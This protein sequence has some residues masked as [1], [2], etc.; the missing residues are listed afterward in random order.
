MKLS[1]ERNSMQCTFTCHDHILALK[2]QSSLFSNG[3]FSSQGQF[4]VFGTSHI[5]VK[6]QIVKQYCKQSITREAEKAVKPNQIIFLRHSFA[7][8]LCKSFYCQ[9]ITAIL[10]RT[11]SLHNNLQN[12]CALGGFHNLSLLRESSSYIA[13]CTR[14]IRDTSQKR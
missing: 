4:L 10:H 14:R 1:C 3:N 9:N 5:V 2:V 13:I 11:V 7:Y 8:F 12:Y 6:F